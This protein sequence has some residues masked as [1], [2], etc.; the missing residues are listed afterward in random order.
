MSDRDHPSIAPEAKRTLE[1]IR[2]K[3]TLERTLEPKQTLKQRLAASF[4]EFGRIAIIT[5]V[6]LSLV[7]IAGFSVA[8]GIGAEPSSAT[9][10]FGVIA[11]GWLAAKAT[12]PIRILIVLALTP[13][14]AAILRR[15]SRNHPTAT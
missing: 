10:V 14:I 3:P 12:M 15:R 9:G 4:A 6:V 11:A 5:Y 8:I 7:T 2:A 13:A 1:P